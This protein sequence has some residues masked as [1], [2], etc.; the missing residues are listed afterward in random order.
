MQRSLARAPW[1]LVALVALSPL[2]IPCSAQD[3]PDP[4]ATPAA[5]ARYAERLLVLNKAGGSMTIFD[6]ATRK[7]VAEVE[8]GTGPHEVAVS[9]DGRTAVVCNYGEQQP[10]STLTVIDVPT[11]TA[12]ATFVLERE[13]EVDGAPKRRTFLRPHGIRFLGDRHVV[14]TSEQLRRL[15]VV[16]VRERKVVRALPT[17]QRTLHMVALAPDGHA[18]Y[19]SSIADGTLGVFALDGDGETPAKVLE[20]GAGA[21]GLCVVPGTGAIW[22]GNRAADTLSVIDPKTHEELAELATQ[23]F[24]IRVECTPDGKSVLVSCAE[25]GSVQV[26]DTATRELRHTIDL[27]G[28]ESEQSPLPIG[29]CIDRDGRFAYVACARGEYLAVID[30]TAFRMVDRIPAGPGPDGM[31]WAR[32]RTAEDAR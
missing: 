10:G 7:P 27:Q 26:F 19:G 25:A 13:E 6:P 8:V 24:P 29:I 4:V 20:T 1:R 18:A 21:E 5:S 32:W 17:Q 31:A 15:L 23:A 30:L 3:A 28:E 2:S 11:G 14:V 16:D 12:T 9:P 22:V